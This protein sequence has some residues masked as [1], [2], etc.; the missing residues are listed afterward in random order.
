MNDEP[1]ITFGQVCDWLWGFFEALG[2][3]VALLAVLWFL[4]KV[5]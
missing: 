1:L 3:I 5:H 2:I 4:G